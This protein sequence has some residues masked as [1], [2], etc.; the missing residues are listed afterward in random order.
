MLERAEPVR[1]DG[2]VAIDAIHSLPVYPVTPW[3]SKERTFQRV[4][5]GN[6]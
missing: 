4:S 5:D 6:Q 2:L 1:K 3:R